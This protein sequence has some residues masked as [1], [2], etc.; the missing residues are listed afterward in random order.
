VNSYRLFGIAVTSDR[1][2]PGSWT[3]A[4]AA[5]EPTAVVAGDLPAWSGT[6]PGGWRGVVDGTPFAVECS[7]AGEHRFCAGDTALFHLS[8]DHLVLISQSLAETDIRWWRLLLDPVLFT[9][10]LLRGGDALHA[11]A[12]AT[13]SGVVALVAGS[14]AGKSTLLSELLRQGHELVTDDILFIEATDEGLRAHPGPPLMT[15]PRERADGAG[16]HLGEIGP[17]VWSTVPVVAGPR[18]LRRV[19]LLDRQPGQR[20]GVHAVE[21]P[22]VPLMSHLLNFP[23]TRARELGR[24]SLA[25]SLARHVEVR[26]VLADVEASPQQLAALAVDDLW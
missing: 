18:P 3:P 13:P 6:V 15:L 22:V 24:F 11:G 19:V 26:S 23:A 7:S 25:S 1:P 14:G 4:P 8:A 5:A 17:E 2:F 9:V 10:A 12:V 21:S 20:A 16:R